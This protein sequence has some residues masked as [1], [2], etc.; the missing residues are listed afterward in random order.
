MSLNSRICV[1]ID[2]K[3]KLYL[4]LNFIIRYDFEIVK[5]SLILFK[6]CFFS[7][8][9]YNLMATK[10]QRLEE[11][12]NNYDKS[13]S[14]D[15]LLHSFHAR[16][17]FLTIY[18]LLISTLIFIYVVIREYLV[19]IAF[20]TGITISEIICNYGEIGGISWHLIL[21][22]IILSALFAIL[23]MVFVFMV[24]NRKIK[25][26]DYRNEGIIAY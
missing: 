13:L 18:V 1:N 23:A 21:H 3:S 22:E 17:Q 19:S 5:Y 10:G 26:K 9:S 20:M 7:F 25:V 15:Q 4:R 8:M 24:N 14:N 2:L 16:I 11:I 12:I 6:I